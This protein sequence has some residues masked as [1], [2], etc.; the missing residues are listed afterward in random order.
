VSERPELS[1]IV[2]SYNEEGRLGPTVGALRA[3]LDAAAYAAELVLVDDGSTD[4]TPAL[5]LAAADSEPRIQPVILPDNRGKGAAVRAGVRAARG[6]WMVFL[7]AD[8]SYD[9][10]A[11]DEARA[12]I[13]AGADLAVGARDLHA[14]DTRRGYAPARRLASW[15]FNRYA[16]ALL[17]LGV[18]DTQCGFKAF[19]ADAGRALFES[20]TIEGFGFD[21]EL[22]YLARRWGL[23]IAPFPVAMQAR[24]GSSVSLLRH[25]LTMGRDVWRVRWQASRGRYPGTPAELSGRSDRSGSPCPRPR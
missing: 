21:V 12:L 20:L 1:V 10:A 3:W 14:T 13:Q 16:E 24:E 8:L 5:I 22:L 4:R 2:P 9:L 7:D 15:A 25:S 6:E 11:I 19:R 18:R 23:A 17:G